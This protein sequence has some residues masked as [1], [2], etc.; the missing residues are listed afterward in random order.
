MKSAHLETLF[1]TFESGLVNKRSCQPVFKEKKPW[2]LPAKSS[3]HWRVGSSLAQRQ[4]IIGEANCS[5]IWVNLFEI[6]I[7]LPDEGSLQ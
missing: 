2:M 5:K 6:R 7:C 4:G 1:V 3:L